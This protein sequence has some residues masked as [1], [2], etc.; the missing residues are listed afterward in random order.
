SNGAALRP[1]RHLARG[2]RF[3]RRVRDVDG[4]VAQPRLTCEQRLDDA[5]RLR[6]AAATEFDERDF[7]TPRRAL[8]YLAGAAR[9]DFAF[10][11]RQVV[12]RQA[13]DGLEELRAEVV[14]EVF[15]REEFPPRGE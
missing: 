12:F 1:R 7:K 8:D 5:A 13:T 9:E 10:G 3:E 6:G 14:V 11:A 2:A 4:D 15:R